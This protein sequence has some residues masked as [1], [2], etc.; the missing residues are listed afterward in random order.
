MHKLLARGF[1]YASFE[2][3]PVFDGQFTFIHSSKNRIH[4]VS[5][6]WSTLLFFTEV[7]AMYH[8]RGF[9]PRTASAVCQSSFPSPFDHRVKTSLLVTPSLASV[10]LENGTLFLLDLER[11]E[12]TPLFNDGIQTVDAVSATKDHLFVLDSSLGL[13]AMYPITSLGS[14][15]KPTATLAS[16][17]TACNL[18]S[19]NSHTLVLDS[20]GNVFSFGSGIQGELGTGVSLIEVPPEKAGIIEELEGLKAVRVVAGGA[21]SVVVVD[22]GIPYFL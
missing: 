15:S 19:G 6:L 13:I 5:A 2:S 21:H 7:P 1:D 18:S 22:G 8:I 10:I 4:A 3:A 11:G 17:P 20:L 12:V 14:G 16:F 9:S